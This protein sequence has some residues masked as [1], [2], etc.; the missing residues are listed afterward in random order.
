[1]INFSGTPHQFETVHSPED[2]K[3]ELSLP[4]CGICGGLSHNVGKIAGRPEAHC[5]GCR[6]WLRDK[7]RFLFFSDKLQEAINGKV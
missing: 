3:V 7:I 4:K 2:V 6:T 1:M 5:A